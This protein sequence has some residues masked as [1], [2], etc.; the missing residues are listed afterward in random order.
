MAGFFPLDNHFFSSPLLQERRKLELRL[1]ASDEDSSR[2]GLWP[3]F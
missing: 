2:H 3:I 1:K